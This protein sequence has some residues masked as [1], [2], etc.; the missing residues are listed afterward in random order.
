[1]AK[2][3]NCGLENPYYAV[4]CGGCGQEL[5][6]EI[7]KGP[8]QEPTAKD[9]RPP[10]PSPDSSN[11]VR[12][13]TPLVRPSGEKLE[14]PRASLLPVQPIFGIKESRRVG[15]NSTPIIGGTCAIVAGFLGMLQGVVLIAGGP[16]LMDYSSSSVGFNI[17]LG[18]VCLAFGFLSILGG[19]DARVRTKY[20]QSLIRAVLGM[21]S[22]GFLIGAF[23]GL[24]AVILIALSQEEFDGIGD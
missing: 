8:T 1:M 13:A 18:L 10:G 6:E 16:Y 9:A 11:P 12:R 23:L 21:V 3:P 20:R 19:M 24:A 7:K 4:Y 14:V 2:C 5:S 22:Y 15:F 17:L